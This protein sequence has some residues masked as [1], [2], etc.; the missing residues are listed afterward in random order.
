MQYRFNPK[1]GDRLSLLGFGCMRLPKKGGKIDQQASEKLFIQAIEKGINYFDTAYVYF[2]SEV[3]LGTFIA[4]GHRDHVKIATKLP[5]FLVKSNSDFDRFFNK[6]LERLQT[7]YIDYYL[8]HMISDLDMLNKLFTLGLKEWIAAKKQA[9]KILNIGFSFHGGAEH[10]KAL[11]DAY[12]WEFCQIQYNY[13]DEFNQAGTAGLKYAAAK[14]I[15]VIVMEPLRGGKLVTALPREVNELFIKAEPKQSPA[16]CALRWVFNCP[17]VTLAL[18]GMNTKEQL[19]ENITIA[20]NTL[21][22]SM[23][24]EELAVIEKVKMVLLRH[25]KIPCTDC[26]YCL[27]CPAGVNIPACIASY[28]DKYTLKN[29]NAWLHYILNTNAATN[30]PANASLCKNCGSCVKLCPQFIKIP[31]E[32]TQVVK[33]FE[34]PRFKIALRLMRAIMG[35]KKQ[36]DSLS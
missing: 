11:V 36:T 26:G 16:Q 3:A 19:E 14:G 20:E 8:I 2:G 4:K 31:T 23:T 25:I 7:D 18:S 15:A 21:P 34:T 24:K 29:K 10:F 9:G 5:H 22:N 17:E 35:R 6:Q 28:N 1:T 32:L 30:Y 27:P 33:E 12:D 13:L